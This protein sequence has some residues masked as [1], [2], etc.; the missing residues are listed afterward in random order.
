MDLAFRVKKRHE[1]IVE[2]EMESLRG[3][4]VGTLV[5]GGSRIRHIALE[6]GKGRSSF[7]R[8]GGGS[9]TRFVVVVERHFYF[10]NF[11][12]SCWYETK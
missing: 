6:R 10:K 11:L 3:T 4:L 12:R 1:G 9:G 5:G 2:N 7:S 8:A